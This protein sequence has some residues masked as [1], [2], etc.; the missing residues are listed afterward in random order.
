LV[1][2]GSTVGRGDLDHMMWKSH[3]GREKPAPASGTLVLAR[4]GRAANRAHEDF[5]GLDGA[6]DAFEAAGLSE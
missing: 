1:R 4:T 5:T 6:G 3:P 2:H